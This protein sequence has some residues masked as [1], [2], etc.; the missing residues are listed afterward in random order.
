MWCIKKSM[1]V[2]ILRLQHKE[3]QL[4][5]ENVY[6]SG[7]PAEK[8]V[9]GSNRLIRVRLHA[10]YTTIGDSSNV[11]IMGAKE[12]GETCECITLVMAKNLY[13]GVEIVDI[14]DMRELC[15]L[16]VRQ[17]AVKL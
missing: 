9:F 14:V 7:K 1:S 12:R 5:M 6:N 3:N 13:V 16:D 15:P 2:L 11:L 17:F 4:G 8:S 10:H